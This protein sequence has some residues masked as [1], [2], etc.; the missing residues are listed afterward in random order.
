MYRAR[1]TITITTTTADEDADED[2]DQSQISPMP[3]HVSFFIQF[4]FHLYSNP[5]FLHAVTNGPRQ[6]ERES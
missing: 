6:R 4:T 5:Y 2:E 3:R 1:E